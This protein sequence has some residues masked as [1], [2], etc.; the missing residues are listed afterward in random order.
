MRIVVRLSL[1]T[2]AQLV[3][4]S[5]SLQYVC[6]CVCAS[7]ENETLVRKLEPFVTQL[8]FS[9]SRASDSLCAP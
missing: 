8:T 5:A 4:L 9:I 1:Q 6:V 3:S 2:F 7:F